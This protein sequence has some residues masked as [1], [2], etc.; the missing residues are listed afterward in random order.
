MAT[1]TGLD[2]SWPAVSWKDKLCFQVSQEKQW[3]ENMKP[4]H[5]IWPNLA[6]GGGTTTTTKRTTTT[7]MISENERYKLYWDRTILTDRTASNNR[8]DITLI[9]KVKKKPF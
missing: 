9:D 7:H 1:P 4:Q 2:S 8:P 3:E 6:G 5:V